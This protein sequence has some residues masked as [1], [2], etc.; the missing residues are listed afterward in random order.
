[1]TPSM[2]FPRGH[3]GM[4]PN[5]PG[6]GGLPPVQTRRKVGVVHVTCFAPFPAIQ[7]VAALKNVRAFTVIERMDNP[8]PSPIRSSRRSR[9]RS[10][11]P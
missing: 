6:G 7:L 10:R 4:M 1:M 2:H 11:T 9:L 8:L 5:R 3:G